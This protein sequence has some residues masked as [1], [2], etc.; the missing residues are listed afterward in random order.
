MNDNQA[1]FK[2]RIQEFLAF[3]FPHDEHTFK[4]YCGD[5]YVTVGEEKN[6]KLVF[7]V[8]GTSIY[9]LTINKDHYAKIAPLFGLDNV[10]RSQFEMLNEFIQKVNAHA[11]FKTLFEPIEPIDFSKIFLTDLQEDYREY[12][13]E[14]FIKFTIKPKFS[15]TPF[16]CS[17]QFDWHFEDIAD[18]TKLKG[19]MALCLTSKQPV[20]FV[21][22]FNIDSKQAN[23][24]TAESKSY[25]EFFENNEPLK[26]DTQLDTYLHDFVSMLIEKQN[27]EPFDGK[28][29]EFNDLVKL[30]NM[31][32]I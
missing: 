18:N 19:I 12:E 27:K 21:V 17:I 9:R 11:S 25:N 30:F 14:D 6:A 5:F 1:Q 20:R 2:A 7:N 4:D 23:I 15:N 31:M 29:M 16:T 26:L 22:G 13:I 32:K 3:H 28:K 8:I 10:D 24:V